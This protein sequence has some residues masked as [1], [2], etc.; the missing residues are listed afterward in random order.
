[1]KTISRL[2]ILFAVWLVGQ[3]AM[4]ATSYGISVGEVSITSDNYSNVKGTYIKGSVSYSPSSNTLTLKDVTI[5]CENKGGSNGIYVSSSATNGLHIVLQGNNI[6]RNTNGADIYISKNSN[7]TNVYSTPNVYI[8]GTGTLTLEQRGSYGGHI[9]C[10]NG[11]NICFGN[12]TMGGEG[13]GGCTINARCIYSRDNAGGYLWISD[14]NINLTGFSYTS[15]GVLMGGTIYGFTDALSRS[16]YCSYYLPSGSVAMYDKTNLYM[17]NADGGRLTTALHAGWKNFGLRVAGVEVTYGNKS[18]VTIRGFGGTSY[19]LSYDPDTKTLSCPA[20]MSIWTQEEPAIEN[21]I[22]GLT[23]KCTGSSYTNIGSNNSASLSST[24]SV[25]F[26]GTSETRLQLDGGNGLKMEGN[27]KTLKFNTFRQVNL[28]DNIEMNGGTLQFTNCKEA[29]LNTKKYNFQGVN[30]L[31]LENMEITTEK[32]F[33]DSSQGCFRQYGSSQSSYS[34]TVYM[35]QVSQS[36]GI[37]VGYHELNDLN[38]NNFYYEN[39]EGDVSYDNWNNTLTLN[40]ATVDCQKKY[41]GIYVMSSSPGTVNL[42][43][44]GENTIKNLNGVGVIVYNNIFI[45][46]PG[47]LTTDNGIY[48]YDGSNLTFRDNCKVNTTYNPQN[49]LFAEPKTKRLR[50]V[51][52]KSKRNGQNREQNLKRNGL[53]FDKHTI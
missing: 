16:S 50:F 26:S 5:D 46:G 33:F 43:L 48:C 49:D 29:E 12:F 3:T 42:V 53:H 25:T 51:T 9:M 23:I 47:S 27:G 7:Y 24:G 15:G 39:I 8:Q 41:N 44:Q 10:M 2:F 18:H 13:Y 40:N 45:K 4:S 28:L 1:M 37:K 17:K 31:K 52:T 21:T 30:T 32:V 38:C 6:I 35:A 14:A 11:V 34:G 36:Y 20:G 22:D 19:E